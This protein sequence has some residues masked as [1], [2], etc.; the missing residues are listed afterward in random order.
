MFSTYFSYIERN[1]L[2]WLFEK[3]IPFLGA[4]SHAK[5]KIDFFCFFPVCSTTYRPRTFIAIVLTLLFLSVLFAMHSFMD[6]TL[7]Q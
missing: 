7:R 4:V 3:L 2:C 1:D 5:E 6:E